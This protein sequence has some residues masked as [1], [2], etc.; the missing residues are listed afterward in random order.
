MPGAVDGEVT[1]AQDRRRGRRPARQRP[2]A[3][4]ELGEHERLAEVV[5]RAQ[6]Q[7]VDPVLD[8]GGGGEHEDP[9]AGAG[10][11]P[12]H[13]VTMHDRQVAVEHDHVIRRPRGGLQRR[14]AV[15]DGVHG[16]PRLTQPLSDPA[17]K[18]RMVLDHQHPHPH[19][20]CAG[21]HDI[22]STSRVALMSSAE[23]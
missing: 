5:V 11:R 7:P 9:R 21:R 12:A 16:H 8:L 14:R 20:V 17:G 15:V 19:Q 3:R 6:L 13:L 18:R 1:A 10:E 2:H 4:D 22:R 23:A